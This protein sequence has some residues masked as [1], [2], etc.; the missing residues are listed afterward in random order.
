MNKNT[1]VHVTIYSCFTKPSIIVAFCNS[2]IWKKYIYVYINTK[3]ISL[4]WKK[5]YAQTQLLKFPQNINIL[6]QFYVVLES[7][8][9]FDFVRVNF[10][11][12][13]W[14]LTIKN[15]WNTFIL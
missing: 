15:P 3:N 9:S 5:I 7:Q 11:N 10:V 13:V 4:I 6:F 1:Q 14:R 2:R 12:K 8:P